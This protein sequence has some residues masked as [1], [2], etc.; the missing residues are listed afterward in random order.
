[1]V[2]LQKAGMLDSNADQENLKEIE[3][4]ILQL[5]IIHVRLDDHLYYYEEMS[6]VIC[7]LRKVTPSFGS[8]PERSDR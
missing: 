1:M 4:G 8:V 6:A 3:D 7:R 5:K 2:N